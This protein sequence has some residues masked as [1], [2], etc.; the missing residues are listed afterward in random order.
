MPLLAENPLGG[1]FGG[2]EICGLRRAFRSFFVSFFLSDFL[3]EASLLTLLV[4]LVADGIADGR[5]N[6][7]PAM[8]ARRSGPVARRIIS[9]SSL[10]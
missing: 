7:E 9:A 4:R 5:T 10:P 3:A 1:Q 6:P 2:G 8:K